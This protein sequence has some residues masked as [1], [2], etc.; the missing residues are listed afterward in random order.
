MFDV[1]S[2]CNL[3]LS[4]L[5][6]NADLSSIDPP[7]GS[8]QAGHCALFYPLARDVLLESYPWN[9]AVYRAKLALLNESIGGWEYC[10]ARPNDVISII[11]V[12]P[13]QTDKNEVSVEYEVARNSSGDV[14]ILTDEP[15][16]TIKYVS[17]VKDPQKY[18]PMFIDA[19]AWLLASYIAG[20]M[21]KGSEGAG[22]AKNCYQNFLMVVGQAR[23]SEAGQKR[24]NQDQ[25]VDWIAAR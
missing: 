18:S 22:M 3:A 15:L 2:I 4:R 9:F 17:R 6:D 16:A 14:V 19:L 25:T 20:P 1:V 12:L 24:L 10:Y 8:A 23:N 21:I 13:L 5:G 7:E 11:A